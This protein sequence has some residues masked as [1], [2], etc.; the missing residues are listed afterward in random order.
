LR[1]RLF[2]APGFWSYNTC[3]NPTCKLIWPS[4]MPLAEDIGKAYS[5]YYTH[6]SQNK[7]GQMGWKTKTRHLIERVY[8]SKHFGYQPTTVPLWAKIF[9]SFY[10][11]S[12]LHRREAEAA[13]RGLQA[14]PN[15]R[16]FDV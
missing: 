15:G 7:H 2:T 16:L 1:D 9:G 12:P 4:P 8:W 5:T 3:S 6:A 10:Y 14:V 13:I 11:L